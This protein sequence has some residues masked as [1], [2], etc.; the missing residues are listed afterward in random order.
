M[1]LGSL[2][3][4]VRALIVAAPFA[5]VSAC[6]GGGGD[7]GGGSLSLSPNHIEFTA[8]AARY[9]ASPEPVTVTG[10]RFGDMPATAFRVVSPTE[11]RATHPALPAG[12][13]PV[14]VE[15]AEN[16]CRNLSAL[17][18]IEPPVMA[19]ASIA[20][21]PASAWYPRGVVYDAARRVLFVGLLLNDGSGRS[22][23]LRYS[24]D[25]AAW[26]TPR[27]AE[28][29]RLV[30]L[31]L[32]MDG[33]RL[34]VGRDQ[35]TLTQLDPTTLVELNTRVS[36]NN[37]NE[38]LPTLPLTN[39]GYVLGPL[40]SYGTGYTWVM[41]YSIRD[42]A[43][44]E[45]PDGVNMMSDYSRGAASA[46]GSTVLMGKNHYEGDTFQLY[47]ASTGT[48]RSFILHEEADG[49][50]ADR[51]GSRFIIGYS[52]IFD[53]NLT[54]LGRLPEGMIN[55]VLTRDGSRAYALDA[56]HKLWSF[57]LGD[58]GGVFQVTQLGAPVA[59]VAD[60]SPSDGRFAY[61][62]EMTISPDGGTLFF[63]G[64]KSV[65]VMPVP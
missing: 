7:G 52:G 56:D 5:L 25:G 2:G 15:T 18:V 27:Q 9:D 10:V 55:A 12:N 16:V 42:A 62:I 46:D 43:F 23:I 37:P 38:Y 41:K 60:P 40:A 51:T 35:T 24:Y 29:D 11:I 19:A 26:G 33:K 22:R 44:V 13:Y 48:F 65:V 54:L 36:S 1:I 50:V 31:T 28:V 49:M 21:P 3:R 32:S 4:A 53:R 20:H 8:A 58:V 6:G 63:A 45:F 14:T 61:P 59:L 30:S 17:S 57:A 64:V 39:D 47:D 34:L